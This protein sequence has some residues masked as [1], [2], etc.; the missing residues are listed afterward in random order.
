MTPIRIWH[1]RAI[2]GIIKTRAM[3][4]HTIARRTR[5]GHKNTRCMRRIVLIPARHWHTRAKRT[6]DRIR[7]TRAESGIVVVPT[8]CWHIRAKRAWN[9][10]RHT[11]AESWIIRKPAPHWHTKARMAWRS[12]HTRAS[13]VASRSWSNLNQDNP[14]GPQF[15]AH[16]RIISCGHRKGSRIVEHARLSFLGILGNALTHDRTT[17]LGCSINRAQFRMIVQYSEQGGTRNNLQVPCWP[18]GAR[19]G[20]ASGHR[21][22][23]L[24]KHHLGTFHLKS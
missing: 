11:R 19:Y 24:A 17:C 14:W 8:L 1:T 15:G 13:T 5:K 6:L 12:R 21:P 9:R 18:P 10:K 22:P 23:A 3:N 7:H 20:D 4:Q 16:A 2:R